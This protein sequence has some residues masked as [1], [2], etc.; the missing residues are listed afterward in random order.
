MQSIQQNIFRYLC[1]HYTYTYTC[2]YVHMSV[3]VRIKREA[4]SLRLRQEAWEVAE[5]Y[6]GVSGRSYGKVRGK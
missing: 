2:I 3:A 4:I 6:L 1:I 5:W